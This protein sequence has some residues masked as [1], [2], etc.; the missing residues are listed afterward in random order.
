VTWVGCR[1]YQRGVP[2]VTDM[3]SPPSFCPQSSFSIPLLPWLDLLFWRRA[4]ILSPVMTKTGRV[5]EHFLK[6]GGC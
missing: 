4:S 6:V 2:H 5:A 3:L 1:Q